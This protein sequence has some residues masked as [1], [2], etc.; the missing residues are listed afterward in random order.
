MRKSAIQI[1]LL[2]LS[3]YADAQV[4]VHNS[5]LLHVSAIS[6]TLHIN[7]SFIN[8]SSGDFSNNGRFYVKQD[9]TN[10]QASMNAGTG[11]YVS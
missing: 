9:I 4:V 1:L 3:L 8:T 11:T 6:D 2:L 10:S 5:G 7:G